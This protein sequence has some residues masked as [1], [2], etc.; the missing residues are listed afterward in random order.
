VDA[1]VAIDQQAMQRDLFD[2]M[3]G[4]PTRFDKRQKN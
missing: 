4:K 1:R 3:K 2:T